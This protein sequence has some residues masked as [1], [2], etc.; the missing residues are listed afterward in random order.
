MGRKDNEMTAKI[1]KEIIKRSGRKVKFDSNKITQALKKAGEVTEEFDEKTAEKLTIKV[2]RLAQQV[3]QDRNPTVEDIQDCVEEILLNSPYKKSAKACIIYREQHDKIREITSNFNVGVVNQYL[4]KKDWQVQENSNQGFSLQ[5]LNNYVSS[6]VTKTYWLNEIYP[7]E[8]RE[9]HLNGDLHIHDLS[10]LSV[11]CVSSQ[12]H[13]ITCNGSKVAKDVKIGD[14]LIGFD[15]VGFKP[16]QVVE[17]FSR[18]VEE[19]LEIEFEY[20][21][22]KQKIRVTGEHPLLTTVGWKEAKLLVPG[23]EI[24]TATP[25]DLFSFRCEYGCYR[26]RKDTISMKEALK[27]LNRKRKDKSFVKKWKKNCKKAQKKEARYK[28]LLWKDKDWR[29][30]MMQSRRDSGMYQDTSKRMQKNNPMTN[31]RVAKKAIKTRTNRG[32]GFFETNNPM[33]DPI[34]KKEIMKK[35]MSRRLPSNPEKRVIEIIKENKLPIYYVGKAGLFVG[36]YNPDFVDESGNKLVEVFTTKMFNKDRTPDMERKKEYYAKRGKKCLLLNTDI[37]SNKQIGSKLRNFVSNGAKILKIKRLTGKQCGERKYK[38]KVVNFHCEPH[39]NFVIKGLISHNCVGWDL[40][41]LLMNGFGGVRVKTESKPAKHLSSALGQIINF[42]YTLQ[43]EAAGAQ[44]FSN[45]DTLLAP[46][47]KYDKLSYKN[48]KQLLQEFIFNINVPTRAGF[49]AP[50]TNITFDLMVSP[51]YE[52]NKVIVGGKKQKE[53]YKDFQREMDIFNKAFLEVMLEG[54]AKGTVFTFPVP[55]YNITKVFDWDNSNAD[56][57]WEVT[58]KYGLPYFSNF[59]NSDMKPEDARS[60]CCRLRLDTR[61][62]ENRGGGLFGANPLTGSVGVVTINMPRLGYLSK[63]QDEFLDKLDKLMCLA[64]ESLEIKRKVLEKFTEENLYPYTKFYLRSVKER[65]GQYWKNHFSTIGLVGMNEACL[66]LVKENIGSVN[67]HK[68]TLKVLDFMRKK[69]IEFQKETGN[70]Y[71]LEATPAESTAYRLA[72]LDKKEF[73]D[74]ICANEEEYKKGAVEYYTNSTQLPVGYTDDFLQVLDLQDKI[75]TKF[76]GG[77][78]LHL[79]IGEKRPSNESIKILVKKI[80]EN[81]QLPYFTI[82]PKT[83]I[84]IW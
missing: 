35:A 37:L 40:Y 63:N 68:F 36:K 60:M 39:N 75:Q 6:E 44:A 79:F 43:G 10:Y 15:G 46:F 16:T 9:V 65:F 20:Y 84:F 66:N 53:Y 38:Y 26:N 72:K 45:F 7:K 4:K 29:N 82:T 28:K 31:K 58:S 22:K 14:K 32:T 23:D 70:N 48:V 11:Y 51:I 81:Y 42:F 24:L 71:N 80:C 47:I 8:I 57:L 78:V 83:W 67:G 34:K 62:L 13:I 55:T 30:K 2:L 21:G 50:F 59:I 25:K 61:H 54:D 76:T 56:L 73:E 27:E 33:R 49:Q 1:F 52:Y 41:D 19:L 5:G 12:E 17:V 77:T 3:V 74:I 18:E 69:L 64:K